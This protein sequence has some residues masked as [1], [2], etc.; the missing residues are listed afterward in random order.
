MHSKIKTY[1]FAE[2][3]KEKPLEI[4]VILGFQA[5]FMFAT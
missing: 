4:P 2:N 1:N 5:V 3:K